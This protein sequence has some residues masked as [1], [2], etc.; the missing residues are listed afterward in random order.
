M[1]KIVRVSP[2]MQKFLA[3]PENAVVLSSAFHAHGFWT[4]GVVLMRNLQFKAKAALISFLFLLPMGIMASSYYLSNLE[5][6]AFSSKEQLGVEY[7]REIFPVL[8]LAQQL[9][10]DASNGAANGTTPPTMAEIKEKLQTARAKL[11]A[12]DNRLGGKL[13]TAKAF[14]AVEAAYVKANSSIGTVDVV[15]KAHT[16]HIQ[17]LLDLMA[18][19]T[20]SS[21]LTL[22]PEITSFYVMDSVFVRLSDIVEKTAQLRG[23]GLIVLKSGAITKEQ[24]RSLSEL[25]PI[26]EYQ[27]SNI[28]V[29]LTKVSE[30]N[31]SITDNLKSQET[32]D[33]TL[34]F[35]QL[36][37]K[38]VIDSQD[39]SSEAQ[40]NYLVTA[41]KTIASQYTLA[42]QLMNQL[43]ELLAS[44]I[45]QMKTHLYF[46]SAVL[47]V[48]VLLAFYFF[49]TF[50]LVTRGGLALI[51]KH[52]REMADGDLRRTP[53]KPWGSDEPAEVII[54]LRHAYDSL[55][56]LIRT[57]RHSARSLHATSA[58]IASAS[59]DLSA[60]T[61]SAAASLEEQSAAM[62][63]IGT[64]VDNTA[65]LASLAA[66]FAADNANVAED[67]GK[68]IG[69]VVKTMQEIHASS[70]QINDIIGVIN[71]IAFQTN[72]LALNAAV[73]AARA[74]EAG[75]G[76]AVVA[77]EV[78]SLAQRS[79]A[80]ATEIKTLISNSVDQ[81]TSGTK[82]VEKAGATMTMMVTNAK[83]INVYLSDI[84]TASREQAVGVT[85]V[86]V[87]IHELDEDTQK[88]AALV[89]ETTAASAALTQQAETLQQEIAN[90]KVA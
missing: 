25:I 88:N 33:A 58:E 7:N 15:Y 86:G 49:Y 37:R 82:V 5:S 63:E 67:G 4:L 36:A 32:L 44:R 53:A 62:E 50:Y 64:T 73:E 43:D 83:Q 28:N 17:A 46:I 10:R 61:E 13:G 54:D 1:T 21:N 55:H 65:E 78:R 12:V 8:N 68:V 45:V 60:R 20:D 84:S 2:E 72:I 29:G 74:G 59:Y 18:N 26:A 69:T 11:A 48:G 56:A 79:A 89:E 34:A 9:R 57:V 85:Q 66:K 47:V 51:R 39:F 16:E 41:N 81:I 19:V 75:R 22:D 87:A 77:S 70:S 76:F 80:A 40:A 23:R 24:Q 14:A 3:A 90:F 6:I 42:D 71:G 35:N 52:L 30:A 27:F 31:K 38:V